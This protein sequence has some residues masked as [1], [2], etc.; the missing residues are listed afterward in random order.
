MTPVAPR[1]VN[2]ISC[3][4]VLQ[5]HLLLHKA[6]DKILRERPTAKKLLLGRWLLLR[7]PQGLRKKGWG[8]EKMVRR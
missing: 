2:D 5:K 3:K 1:N 6:L 4:F 7:G 8:L